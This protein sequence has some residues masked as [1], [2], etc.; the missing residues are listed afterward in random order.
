MRDE[1]RFYRLRQ[2]S[3]K[4]ATV[5]LDSLARLAGHQFRRGNPR[6]VVR[7]GLLVRIRVA[8]AFRALVVTRMPARR[9][10]RCLPTF[11][12]ASAVTARLSLWFG[13][14]TPGLLRSCGRCRR[15]RGGGTRFASRSRNANGESSTT[16]PAPGRVDCRPRPGQP[17]WPPCVG[18]ARSGL[19][20]RGRLGRGSRRVGRA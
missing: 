4:S 10:S 17:S 8:A 12:M 11:P 2:G 3:Y 5:A 15:F 6:G 18:R 16:P 19:W 13:E 20:R 7:A 14:N 9:A 1:I